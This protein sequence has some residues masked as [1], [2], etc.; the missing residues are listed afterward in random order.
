[1]QGTGVQ[2][3]N[4]EEIVESVESM[5]QEYPWKQEMM[6]SHELSHLMAQQSLTFI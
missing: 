1:M 2:V 6:G 3:I 4:T 5:R